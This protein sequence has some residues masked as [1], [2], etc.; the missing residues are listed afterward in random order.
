MREYR[1]T[2]TEPGRESPYRN[3]SVEENLDL[4][5]AHARRRV[6]RRRARAARQDRH[7]VG[8]HQHARSGACIASARHASPHGRRVVH[9]SDVRLRA[10]VSP[11]PSKAS[12]IRCAR[13]STKITARSTTGISTHSVS[14]HPRQIEFARLNLS[15]TMM[16]KRKLLELV[17]GKH[18]SGWDDPRMPTLS[19]LRRR[20]YTPEGDPQLLR[21]HRRRQAR[22]RRRH[23][24]SRARD[25]R[26]SER[27]RAARHG[28]AE[29]AEGRHR[30]L[31]RRVRSKRSTSST[32]PED[33]SAGTRKVPFGRVLYIERDDFMEDP[34]KKFFRLS[35]GRKCAC[36][37]R[38]SSD[39]RAS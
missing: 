2:L 39:A 24:E 25:P 14:I 3:R 30:E 28:R 5:A 7:G 1:G 4:F 34:P 36:G 29:S 20:G 6:R 17:E 10:P 31:S 19:G 13:S 11:I 16:S 23:R 32:I 35:P 8:Q 15:Y 26:G 18:V 38:T 33:P 27:A 12:R 22:E 37:A 21:A 9:L